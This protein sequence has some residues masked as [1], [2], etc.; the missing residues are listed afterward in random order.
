MSEAPGPACASFLHPQAPQ[1]S[2]PPASNPPWATLELQHLPTS[3]Q[4]STGP[5]SEDGAVV[6]ATAKSVPQEGKKYWGV[7]AVHPLPQKNQPL[8]PPAK[9]PCALAKPGTAG[10]VQQPEQS[11]RQL[12]WKS[13]FFVVVF[14]CSKANDLKKKKDN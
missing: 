6:L 5:T 10:G 2:A 12:A 7:L 8:S 11:R 9:P 4:G 1:L 3:Q 14:K 13:Q